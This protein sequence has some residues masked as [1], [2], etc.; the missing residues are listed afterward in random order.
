MKLRIKRWR[1][2]RIASEFPSFLWPDHL[3][4]VVMLRRRGEEGGELIFV[5]TMKVLANSDRKF[6]RVG[7][8]RG[9]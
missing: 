6:E 8:A 2:V 1:V 3:K 9:L 7:A 5:D 4:S